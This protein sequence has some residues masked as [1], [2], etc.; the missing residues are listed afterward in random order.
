MTDELD[1]YQGR[2]RRRC[3]ECHLEVEIEKPTRVLSRTSNRAWRKKARQEIA[4]QLMWEAMCKDCRAYW[5]GVLRVVETVPDDGDRELEE[6][7]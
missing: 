3:P 2:V 6:V 7:A 4:R 5:N 1:I